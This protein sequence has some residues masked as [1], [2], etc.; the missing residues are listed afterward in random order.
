MVSR[1]TTKVKEDEIMYAKLVNK[2]YKIQLKVILPET[3]EAMS[4]EK[5]NV[6]LWHRRLGHLGHNNLRKLPH[7][8]HGMNLIGKFEHQ[9]CD[10]CHVGKQTR[11]EFNHSV[12]GRA[13]KPLQL[14]HM[15][16]NI[17]N[18][19]GRNG[20]TVVLVLTDEATLCKFSFPMKSRSGE[21]IWTHFQPWLAWAQAASGQKLRAVRSD[22]A[23][24][25]RQGIFAMEMQKRDVHMEQNVK[26]EHE[27]NGAAE[28][29]NRILL[30]RA[31][32]TLIEAYGEQDKNYGL[33]Q[34]YVLHLTV[35]DFHNCYN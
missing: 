2:K 25:F 3:A 8:V 5:S 26:Y 13:K 21:E 14:V 33:M 11:R 6:E 31:K 1:N 28:I 24:E 27:Q 12:A 34:L 16:F 22:N 9:K 30:D 10:I 4:A 20:E 35:F 18:V 15:D 23:K 19:P 32:C 29:S 17:I 7:M